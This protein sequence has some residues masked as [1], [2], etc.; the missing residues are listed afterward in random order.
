[1]KLPPRYL[2]HSRYLV[3]GN[4]CSPLQWRIKKKEQK[5]CYTSLGCLMYFLVFSCFTNSDEDEITLIKA[6]FNCLFVG[7]P[8]PLA[9]HYHI[10]FSRDFQWDM[11][12]LFNRSLFL[13]PGSRRQQHMHISKSLIC[14]NTQALT[15]WRKHSRRGECGYHFTFI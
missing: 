2:A 11:S 1:M 4:N 3:S 12:V 10:L 6:M 13:V 15:M 8:C 5:D 14:M 9:A 7:W